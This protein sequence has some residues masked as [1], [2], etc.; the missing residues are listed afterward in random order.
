[1]NNTADTMEQNELFEIKQDVRKLAIKLTK[2]HDALIGNEINKDGGIVKRLID[3]EEGLEVVKKAITE[4]E[5][6]ATKKGVYVNI[7]Y[8]MG[9]GI[10][11]LI[12]N[13]FFK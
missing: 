7:I 1:V 13:H 5:K 8:L 9:G 3:A 11:T 6:Q 4:I 10:V 2:V 12:I